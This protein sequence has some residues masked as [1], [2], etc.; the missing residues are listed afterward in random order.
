MLKP[1]I[2]THIRASNSHIN[3]HINLNKYFSSLKTCIDILIRILTVKYQTE[4]IAGENFLQKAGH[5]HT[6]L[7]FKYKNFNKQIK[8]SIQTESHFR[9]TDEMK[10][11]SSK[12]IF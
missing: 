10:L 8:M 2:N 7:V 12:T 9:V 5:L 6:V 4:K 3:M 1:H 11:Y